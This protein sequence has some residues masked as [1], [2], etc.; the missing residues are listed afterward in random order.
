MKK[1]VTQTRMTLEDK[2]I[3]M[4]GEEVYGKLRKGT[5]RHM[6]M[7]KERYERKKYQRYPHMNIERDNESESFL[8]QLLLGLDDITSQDFIHLSS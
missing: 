3:Y 1:Y 7:E 6:W 4:N 2:K 8:D 5:Q